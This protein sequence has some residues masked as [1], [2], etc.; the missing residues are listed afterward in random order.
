MIRTF[1]LGL[2]ALAALAFLAAP[3]RAG[4]DAAAIQAKSRA[5]LTKLLA[6][7]EA[8]RTVSA[9][10]RGVLVF[11]KVTKFG[12]VAGGAT[13]KGTLFV[14]GSARGTYRF[15]AAS[16][17]L[18]VGAQ[19]FGYALFFMDADTLAQLGN[20]D[21]WDVGSAPHFIFGTDGDAK[22][23][24]TTSLDK[25]V[26]VFIFDQAGLAGGLGVE[27]SKITRITP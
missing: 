17:G 3:A 26:Y 21:G 1:V 22:K 6:S 13:G 10:A 24:S 9:R 11:P 2:A 20:A 7:E 15:D 23:L 4:D 25:D 19:E 27:G 5:A 16:L 8:A 14:G 18:Q 12:L